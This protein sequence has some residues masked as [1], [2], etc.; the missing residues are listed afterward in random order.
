ME[1]RLQR[2]GA[3]MSRA[4]IFAC[5]FNFSAWPCRFDAGGG[6]T[7]VKLRNPYSAAWLMRREGCRRQLC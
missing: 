1:D 7:F 4:D 6:A 5:E 3:Q 2:D